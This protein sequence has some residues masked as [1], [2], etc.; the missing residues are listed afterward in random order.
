MIAD[1]GSVFRELT[2]IEIDLVS[3]GDY[4]GEGCTIT[5]DPGSGG[6]GGRDYGGPGYDPGAGNDTGGDPGGSGAGS[7]APP[8]HTNGA[9]DAANQ[10][11]DNHVHNQGTTAADKAQFEK[12]HDNMAKFY[13]FAKSNPNAAI[14]ISHNQLISMSQAL[15]AVSKDNIVITDNAALAGDTGAQT[16]IN[17]DGSGATTYINPQ[18]SDVQYL[19]NFDGG[20]DWQMFHELGHVIDYYY[21]PSVVHDEAAANATGRSVENALGITLM[22]DANGL[23]DPRGG[24]D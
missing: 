9:T 10:F 11:A 13:D 14:A 22:S 8:Y 21:Q 3:G 19:D 6:D 15:D 16:S 12:A 17:G 7:G 20:H 5:G 23:V 2:A 4:D 1:S 18:N 24:Y